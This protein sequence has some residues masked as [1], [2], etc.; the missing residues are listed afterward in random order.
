MLPAKGFSNALHIL[1][2]LSNALVPSQNPQKA[3]YLALFLHNELI[4]HRNAIFPIRL[5]FRDICV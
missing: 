3:N 1:A 5:V 2:S 4:N